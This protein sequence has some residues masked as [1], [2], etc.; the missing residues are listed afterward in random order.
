MRPVLEGDK[1]I[2]LAITEPWAG[3]DVSGIRTKAI[4]SEDKTHYIVTGMKKFITTGNKNIY[5]NFY[6]LIY[7]FFIY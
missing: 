4:L 5:I 3:S 7:L 2:C 1:L 6:L